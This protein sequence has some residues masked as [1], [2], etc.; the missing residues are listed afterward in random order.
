[1][2]IDGRV[3]RS[4]G[5]VLVVTVGNVDAGARVAV[6]LRQAEVNDE[7]LVAVAANAHQEVVGLYVLEWFAS[8]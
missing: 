5:Q 6:L 8:S 4:A 2:R 3:A 7:Q 1:M